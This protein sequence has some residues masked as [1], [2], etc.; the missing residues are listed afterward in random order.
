MECLL[1]FYTES[2]WV[3]S[4]KIGNRE[5]LVAVADSENEKSILISETRIEGSRKI[6]DP[7]GSQSQLLRTFTTNL[8][9]FY[10]Y[11]L[12]S[13]AI[14]SVGDEAGRTPVAKR[15]C[16][17]WFP[18]LNEPINQGVSVS[19][20][21]IC[22][23]SEVFQVC[24]SVEGDLA[25]S[26]IAPGVERAEYSCSKALFAIDTGIITGC[27]VLNIADAAPLTDHSILARMESKDETER[28]TSSLILEDYREGTPSA[29]LSSEAPPFIPTNCNPFGILNLDE[30]RES[31]AEVQK[32]PV[33]PKVFSGK[34]ICRKERIIEMEG[35]LFVTDDL[36]HPGT[37][38]SGEL[39]IRF[40][41]V[42]KVIESFESTTPG[43]ITSNEAGFPAP[44]EKRDPY[45]EPADK[46]NDEETS[47]YAY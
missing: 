45:V 35:H 12:D 26:C 29:T 5:I 43:L 39:N 15:A 7:V 18:P 21:F 32:Q 3:F 34:A 14:G 36:D 16:W 17:E 33:A 11:A 47:G 44:N 41:E 37:V 6:S 22:W 8:Q 31:I 40:I 28:S 20:S 25:V 23:E 9:S 24:K 2:C 13:S 1:R 38:A 10:R 46:L 4:K 27:Q 19:N 30:P 42:D